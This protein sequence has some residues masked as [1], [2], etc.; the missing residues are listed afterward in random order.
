MEIWDILGPKKGSLLVL[1]TEEQ[2]N[3]APLGMTRKR[4]GHHKDRVLSTETTNK[5]LPLGAC[6]YLLQCQVLATSEV[7]HMRWPKL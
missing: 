3:V 2:K 6:P 1:G 5:L 4:K 7:G